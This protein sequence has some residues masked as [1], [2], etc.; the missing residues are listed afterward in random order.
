[1]GERGQRG[2]HQHRRSKC[3]GQKTREEGHDRAG[4]YGS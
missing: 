3:N 4:F 2:Q 1:L